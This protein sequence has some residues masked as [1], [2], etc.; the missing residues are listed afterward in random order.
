MRFFTRNEVVGIF[1]IFAVLLTFSY[2][3]FGISLRRSRDA[4]RRGDLGTIYNSLESFFSDYGFFPPS[5]SE[6]KIVA[7]KASNFDAV[8]AEVAK[9]DQFNMEL[10]IS[11]LAPC[12]W[13]W[14]GLHDFNDGEVYLATLPTDPKHQEGLRYFY[15]SN[16]RRYQIYAALEGGNDEQGYNEAIIKRNLNCG[17]AVCNFGRSF[18]VTPLDKSLSE[19]ENELLNQ[20]GNQ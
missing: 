12:D 15:I 7:C 13:G 4:T 6:G 5:N 1:L 17:V 20:R 8:I 16:G 19:Y 2:I 14:D 10:F 3:N 18:S 9:L 11:G